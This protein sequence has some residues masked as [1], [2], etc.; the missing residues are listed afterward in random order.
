MRQPPQDE[1]LE[2]WEGAEWL[3]G[4]RVEGAGV[5]GAEWLR[6]ERVEGA[7][8]EGAEWLISHLIREKNKIASIF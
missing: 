1:W 3:R 4:E 6:G 8:V 5:E 2:S 7:G